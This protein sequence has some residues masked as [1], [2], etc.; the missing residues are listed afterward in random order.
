MNK[1]QAYQSFLEGFG[2]PVYDSGTVPDDA[3]LPYITYSPVYDSFG[4]TIPTNISLWYRGTKWDAISLKAEE[5]SER[6]TRGGIM[7]RY[8]D[9]A[10]WIQKGRP[11]A[12]RMTDPDDT[13][14]RIVLNI[15]I[16][17]VD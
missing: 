11:W 3:E 4:Y 16:E 5:I 12:Q 17:F 8:D 13:I 1:M 2:L 15:E 14:R 10:M 9:G 7:L 6:I